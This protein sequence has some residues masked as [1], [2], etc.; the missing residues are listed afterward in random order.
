MVEV[1]SLVILQVY[2]TTKR[3]DGEFMSMGRGIKRVL[4][5]GGDG[6]RQDYMAMTFT[7]DQYQK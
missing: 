5:G 6:G 1:C 2:C 4:C 3:I 7:S